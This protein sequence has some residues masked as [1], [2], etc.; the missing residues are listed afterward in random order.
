LRKSWDW[1]VK[2]IA[3]RA[4]VSVSSLLLAGFATLT[5]LATA[6]LLWPL[7]D[8]DEL[9]AFSLPTA[10][11]TRTRVVVHRK[12]TPTAFI[13]T[14]TPVPLIHV[15]VEGEVLG[16]IAEEYGTTL[17]ALLEANELEEA[18]LVSIGQELIVVDAK[19]TPVAVK[20]ALPT[21]TAT[22][23]SAFVYAAPVLIGP[24]DGAE[25]RGPSTQIDLQWTSVA[26]L[27]ENEWYEVKLWSLRQGNVYRFWTKTSSWTVPVPL[28]PVDAERVFHWNVMVVQRSDGQSTPLSFAG[29]PRRFGWY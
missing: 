5:A 29:L 12:P 23:T 20:L 24:A 10:S 13:P 19:G 17:E 3:E 25:F 6:W 9:T 22:R 14:A 7:Y 15:V 26:I 21:P 8:S 28:H 1:L 4:S 2:R 27:G 11:P 16:L 18:D